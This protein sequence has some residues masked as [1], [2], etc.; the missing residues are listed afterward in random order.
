MVMSVKLILYFDSYLNFLIEEL[1]LLMVFLASIFLTL[2][3][4]LAT[5]LLQNPGGM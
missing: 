1:L 5:N 3:I 2:T 4:S